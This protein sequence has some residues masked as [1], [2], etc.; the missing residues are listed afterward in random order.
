M[1][2]RLSKTMCRKQE[3]TVMPIL[4]AQMY[5]LEVFDITLK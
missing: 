2:Q 4:P 3:W 1:Y 5:E